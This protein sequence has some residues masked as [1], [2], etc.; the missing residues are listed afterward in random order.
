M[1]LFIKQKKTRFDHSANFKN[2]VK[3]SKYCI[4]SLS[5]I[6]LLLLH[7]YGE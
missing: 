3:L 2:I 4:R 1:V 7:V 5:I 6:L